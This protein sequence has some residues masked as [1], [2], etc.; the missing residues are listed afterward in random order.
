VS[1][2]SGTAGY[3]WTTGYVAITSL[4]RWGKGYPANSASPIC[5]PVEG[6]IQGK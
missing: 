2:T 1:V 4:D 6:I 5:A 3:S